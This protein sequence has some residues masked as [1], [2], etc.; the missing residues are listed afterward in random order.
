[1]SPPPAPLPRP[2]PPQLASARLARPHLLSPQLALL[3]LA[4]PQQPTRALSTLDPQL[5]GR[6]FLSVQRAGLLGLDP[7]H[8]APATARSSKHKQGLRSHPWQ[9]SCSGDRLRC[10]LRTDLSEQIS[11]NRSLRTDLSEQISQNDL[12]ERPLRKTSQK[13]PLVSLRG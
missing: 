5:S 2:A 6:R 9:L 1:M 8:T 13:D 7:F 4:S 11:Q 10:S 12:S 3:C